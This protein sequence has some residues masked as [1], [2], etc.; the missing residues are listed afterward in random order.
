MRPSIAWLLTMN[1]ETLM[2]NAFIDHKTIDL[3]VRCWAGLAEEMRTAGDRLDRGYLELTAY[4]GNRSPER[5]ATEAHYNCRV[6]L[7]VNQQL[8][9]CRNHNQSAGRLR[10]LNGKQALRLWQI[11]EKPVHREQSAILCSNEGFYESH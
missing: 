11:P 5:P 3:S 9:S 7:S 2:I 8:V 4:V 10:R 1:P 6:T